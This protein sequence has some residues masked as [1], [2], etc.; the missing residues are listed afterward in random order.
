MMLQYMLPRMSKLNRMHGMKGKKLLRQWVEA[1]T[2][3]T[4]ELERRHVNITMHPS[5]FKHVLFN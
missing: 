1:P 5:P 3:D 2:W 4:E